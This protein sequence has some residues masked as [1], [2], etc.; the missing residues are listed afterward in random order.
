MTL[1]P[2]LTKT[3]C[4]FSQ[5]LG[6]GELRGEL[7]EQISRALKAAP[8]KA[9]EGAGRDGYQEFRTLFLDKTRFRD[10]STLDDTQAILER[11][12]VTISTWK[13]DI[14]NPCF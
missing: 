8:I 2:L 1:L 3:G 4:A 9:E 11:R 7:S 12:L 14:E 10:S 5:P 13:Q 6:K